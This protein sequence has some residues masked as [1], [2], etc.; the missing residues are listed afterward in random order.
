M[1][2]GTQQLA[3]IQSWPKGKLYEPLPLMTKKVVGRVLLPIINSTLI[4]PQA[5]EALPSKSFE[6]HIGLD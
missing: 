3:W 2:D 4:A 6:H 5:S 1:V